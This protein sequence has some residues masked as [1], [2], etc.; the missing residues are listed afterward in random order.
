M[1]INLWSS[2]IWGW[3]KYRLIKRFSW[4]VLALILACLL[5]LTIAYFSCELTFAR[6]LSLIL[7]FYEFFISFAIILTLKFISEDFIFTIR[8]PC[9]FLCENKVLANKRCYS[10]MF[11]ILLFYSFCCRQ[12]NEIHVQFLLKFP[13]VVLWRWKQLV[14]SWLGKLF[15][16]H[17][18]VFKPQQSRRKEVF[19]AH[20]S[21]SLTQ[22]RHKGPVDHH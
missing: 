8:W 2:E 11:N 6:I 1:E 10:N 7:Y 9:E 20:A 22:R 17:D 4:P 21:E 12:S 14:N 16:K 15:E 19:T 3:Y 18:T 5:W 13:S